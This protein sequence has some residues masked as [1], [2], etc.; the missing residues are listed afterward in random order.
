MKS[1]GFTLI[2]VMV[3]LMVIAIALPAL[4]GAVYR[5]TEGSA[6]LRDKSLAQWVASNKLTET[7]IKQARSGQ[8]FEGKRSGITTMAERDWFWWLDSTVTEVEDF[9]RIE[10]RVAAREDGELQ[11]LITLVGFT[12]TPGT[13]DLPN[14]P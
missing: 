13:R 3:A 7:R 9:Y 10:I 6:H 5:Q 12:V 8:V 4:L 14:G 2:E 11:P 1:R